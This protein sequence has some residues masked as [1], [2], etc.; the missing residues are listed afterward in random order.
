MNNIPKVSLEVDPLTLSILPGVR[1]KR[2]EDLLS[3]SLYHVEKFSKLLHLK[4]Q[5]L[6]CT[7]KETM[8][9]EQM[10]EIEAGGNGGS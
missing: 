8:G 3:F 9:F 2:K 7:E 5:S 6:L 1:A 4:V 10:G